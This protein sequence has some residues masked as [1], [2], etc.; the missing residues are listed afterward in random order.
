MNK[1]LSTLDELENLNFDQGGG[2]VD[3]GEF[4]LTDALNE[5]KDFRRAHLNRNPNHII[6]AYKC[7]S[8]GNSYIH[9]EVML[10]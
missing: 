2:D 7:N 3:E 5:I 6:K 1:E 10:D 8:Q 4:G 9:K